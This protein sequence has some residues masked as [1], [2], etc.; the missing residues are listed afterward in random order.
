MVWQPDNGHKRICGL[1]YALGYHL[2]CSFAIGSE[3]RS[4]LNAKEQWMEFLVLVMLPGVL[5]IPN[6]LSIHC[7]I[8]RPEDGGDYR[9]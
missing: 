5:V 6:T 9:G 1:G 2:H 3:R 4:I 8:H 7:H